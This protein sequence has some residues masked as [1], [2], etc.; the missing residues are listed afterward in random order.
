MDNAR[1]QWRG[2]RLLV[3]SAS[4]GRVDSRLDATPLLVI[5]STKDSL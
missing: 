3:P 5:P 4:H 1:L 2:V